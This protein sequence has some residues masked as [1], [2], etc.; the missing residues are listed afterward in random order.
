[1]LGL[2]SVGLVVIYPVM[3]RFTYWPQAIL[4]VVFNWGALLG[5]SA[6]QVSCLLWMKVVKI[7]F[8][9]D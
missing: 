1:M 5:F 8:S 6:V 9:V 2:A 7:L 3:K 4:A